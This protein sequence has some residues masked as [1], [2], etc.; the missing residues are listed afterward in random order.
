MKEHLG[1]HLAETLRAFRR[2]RGNARTGI[3]V[4]PMWQ[5]PF[6]LYTTY[7][8]LYMMA[9]GCTEA[10]V[11]LLAS[12]GL[13]FQMVLALLS[14]FITDRL[15]RRRPTLIFDLIS[16]TIPTLIWALARN[17]TYFFVAAVINSLVRIVHTSW[18]CLLIDDTTPEQRVHVFT[19]I[20]V[21]GILAGFFAP[22]GGFLV[23]TFSLVSTVRGLYLFACLS[24]TTMFLIR[25]RFTVETKI[26]LQKMAEARSFKARDT[27][28]DYRR[29]LHHLIKSPRTL[30][31]FLLLL[32]NNIHTTTKNTF[33]SILL[34][35]GLGFPR[36]SIAIFPAI[37]SAVLLAGF[38]LVA[39]FLARFHPKRS[40]LIGLL[41][42][43]GGY[44]F[45]TLSP[46]HSYVTVVLST[47]LVALGTAIVFPVVDSLFANSIPGG[48]R[49]KV[50]S[51]FHVFLFGL[52]AP[53]GYIGGLLAGVSERLPFVLLLLLKGFGLILVGRLSRLDADRSPADQP[54]V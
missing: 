7:T 45:L 16:W 37:H 34:A 22:L 38:L 20:Y 43:I 49:A 35:E 33:L 12:I 5:I 40:L 21:A 50:L 2:I 11:G 47:I 41:S 46:E 3:L 26:G 31:A 28:Q 17:F 18:Y 54:S 1:R 6:S 32:I 25:N 10:Q 27:F 23:R 36:A 29:I 4:E 48:D 53:F 51:L 44:L 39:P 9:L 24:M 13:G 42:T 8:S 19:G 15:G 14:G 30:I 52:T